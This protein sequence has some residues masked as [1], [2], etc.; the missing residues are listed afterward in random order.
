MAGAEDYPIDVGGA[1]A[2]LGN[3]RFGQMRMDGE[4]LAGIGFPKIRNFFF[5]G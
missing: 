1:V 4:K 5:I 2:P 3:K